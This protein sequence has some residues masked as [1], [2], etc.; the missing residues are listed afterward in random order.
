MKVANLINNVSA[1][2]NNLVTDG[3]L[4]DYINVLEDMV[5][6]EIIKEFRETWLDVNG[7][8]E[9]IHFP[10]NRFEIRSAVIYNKERNNRIDEI[11][12]LDDNVN[13]EIFSDVEQEGSKYSLKNKWGNCAIKLIYRYIPREKTL[14]NA[15]K[16]ELDITR[17]GLTWY[18]IY[19][20]YLKAMAF[21]SVEE[22][23]QYNNETVLYNEDLTRLKKYIY[24]N[25]Y[26]PTISEVEGR[27]K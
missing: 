25:Y 12:W 5:F 24:D 3:V 15:E 18:S 17:Y 14:E 10:L 4:I 16:D 8:D 27:W 20:H 13:L 23:G 7:E 11:K 6:R 22:Y 21:F 26:N 2:T 19:E 9:L 1:L